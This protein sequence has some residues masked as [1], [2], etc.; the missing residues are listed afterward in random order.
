MTLPDPEADDSVWDEWDRSKSR[1]CIVCGGAGMVRT[2]DIENPMEVCSHC[3]Q[4]QE[5][6]EPLPVEND[7]LVKIR[8]IIAKAVVPPKD[9]PD[10]QTDLWADIQR[11]M[12][13]K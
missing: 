10:F 11:H 9:Q 2:M 6:S 5:K 3:H 1:K 8:E 7:Q 4:K 12:F 13:Q